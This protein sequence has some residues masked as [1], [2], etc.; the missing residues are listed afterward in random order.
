[1]KQ[2][3]ETLSS[4]KG[5]VS[6][7]FMSIQGEGLYAGIRQLF[8]RFYG[9]NLCC[10]FC[11]TELDTYA[12]YTSAEL[13]RKVAGYPPD[14]HSVCFTGAE[15]LTQKDFIKETACLVKAWGLTTYLETNG[16]L[17]R[18]FSGVK[19]HIDIVAM[20]IKLPSSTGEKEQWLAHQEFLS[21]AREHDLFVKIVICQTT[22][23]DDLERAL[24]L[25]A[26]VDSQI[27]LIL[28]PSHK[29]LTAEL[30]H[31]ISGFQQIALR[32]LNDVRIMPQ[33]HKFLNIR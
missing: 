8:V 5:K 7:I 20:D 23:R 17:P 12:E 25:I 3:L 21:S 29:E 16:T 15:P 22:T 9:C 13:F 1:M 19:E 27:P 26:Q 30:M 33:V 31:A 32:F 14:F 10:K 24:S 6:E 2:G 28:Q 4:V 11:D 18:E